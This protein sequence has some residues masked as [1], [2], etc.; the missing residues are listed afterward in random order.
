MDIDA[1]GLVVVVETRDEVLV[2]ESEGEIDSGVVFGGSEDDGAGNERSGERLMLLDNVG[3]EGFVVEDDGGGSKKLI[4]GKV[5][6]E[7]GESGG[8]VE[9]TRGFSLDKAQT[10]GST[11]LVENKLGILALEEDEALEV[12]EKIGEDG[13]V[14]GKKMKREELGRV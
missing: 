10:V 13:I 12:M 1:A 11:R 9:R 6:F 3:G 2:G 7:G 4:L 5:L 8:I 14:A